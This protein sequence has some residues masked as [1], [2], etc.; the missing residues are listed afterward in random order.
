MERNKDYYARVSRNGEK[1]TIGTVGELKAYLEASNLGD[2]EPI[3]LEVKKDK[4]VYAGNTEF[5][6]HPLAPQFPHVVAL[7]DIEAI[8]T[9]RGIVFQIGCTSTAT[10]V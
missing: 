7:N 9:P 5:Y 2:D 1:V 10:E 3:Q 8:S 6:I 4:T